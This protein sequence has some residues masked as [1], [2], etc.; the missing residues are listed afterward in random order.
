MSPWGPV[1]LD[2]KGEPRVQ[3]TPEGEIAY[4][5]AVVA[6]RKKFGPYPG[7]ND[8]SFPQPPVQPGQTHFNPQTGRWVEV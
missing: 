5:K 1:I 3:F 4:R 6:A 7:S 8:P 2:E